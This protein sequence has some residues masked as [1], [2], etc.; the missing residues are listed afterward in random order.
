MVARLA[1]LLAALAL[2]LVFAGCGGASPQTPPAART[3]KPRSGKVADLVAAAVLPTRRLAAIA[4]TP[5]SKSKSSND[6]RDRLIIAI[7]AVVLIALA[8]AGVEVV[9]S[10]RRRA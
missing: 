6:T 3:F 1:R 7:A 10:R 2:V 4:G 9:R 5:V 8:A